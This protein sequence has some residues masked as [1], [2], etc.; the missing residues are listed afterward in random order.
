MLG[1]AL[2][3]YRILNRVAAGGVG[4]IYCARDERL[5]REVALKVL[6]EG[7]L[8]DASARARFRNEAL[9]LSRLNHPAIAT[10][11]DFDSKRSR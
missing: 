6:P 7:A 10:I 8:A 1:P 11:F 9:A 3:H 2:S 4:V 5:E